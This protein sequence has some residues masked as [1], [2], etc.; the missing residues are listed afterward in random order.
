M[1]IFKKKPCQAVG[2][3]SQIP[4]SCCPV[5]SRSSGILQLL[6]EPVLPREALAS[7]TLPPLPLQRE[8]SECGFPVREPKKW[9]EM[10]LKYLEGRPEQM[11]FELKCCLL[12]G[13]RSSFPNAC[14]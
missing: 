10:S 12:S 5:L 8:V 6:G 9:K 4:T 3:S 11:L 13:S 2:G 14:S 7:E 1:L